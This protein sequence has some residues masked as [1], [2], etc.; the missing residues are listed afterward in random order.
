MSY[1]AYVYPAPG[2]RDDSTYARCVETWYPDQGP[3]PAEAEYQAG[4][5][6]GAAIVARILL[7]NERNR[8][9]AASDRYV[10]PDYPHA[11]EEARQAWLAYRQALRDL[12]ENTVDPTAPDWPERPA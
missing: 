1:N 3:P 10:L 8:R 5:A 12:P 6:A 4:H 11:S 2:A 7:R 9:L